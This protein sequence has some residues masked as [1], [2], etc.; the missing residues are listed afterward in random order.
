MGSLGG[1]E[2]ATGF[3]P[4]PPGGPAGGFEPVPQFDSGIRTREPTR[5]GFESRR[6]FKSHHQPSSRGFKSHPGSILDTEKKENFFFAA[7]AGGGTAHLMW[8]RIPPSR[9][10][11]S[12]GASRSVVR[13]RRCQPV[14]PGSIPGRRKTKRNWIF[15]PRWSGGPMWVRIPSDLELMCHSLDG[16]VV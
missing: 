10:I 15:S 8:V 6:G 13:L 16:R 3:E 2:P 11:M 14:G 5:Q 12:R 7:A 1:F 4:A 9:Q